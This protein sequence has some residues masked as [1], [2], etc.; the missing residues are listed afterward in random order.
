MASTNG[1]GNPLNTFEDGF[2]LAV[3]VVVVVEATFSCAT[4]LGASWLNVV[5][6]A[7]KAT[8]SS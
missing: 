2:D 8:F 5:A 3:V 6:V 4:L 7:V 1:S